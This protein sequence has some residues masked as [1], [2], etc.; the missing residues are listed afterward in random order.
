VR[1]LSADPTINEGAGVDLSKLTLGEKII[2]GAGIVLVLDLL[3][4]PW[5]SVDTG[6][7]T[8]TRSGIE[9]PNS[10]WGMLALL[11]TIA[12]VAAVLL[13]KLTTTKLPDLPVAWGQAIFY[14]CIAILALLLIK[15]ISETD[16]LGFGCYLAILLAGGMVYGGFLVSKDPE[17]A[18]P[19]SGPA[20]PF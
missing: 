5:H 14:A 15:L 16:A 13:R 1:Y 11:V 6:F 19:G 9:S 12:T 3:F 7:G 17:T 8:F 2:G 4:F 10:L 18:A 20:T